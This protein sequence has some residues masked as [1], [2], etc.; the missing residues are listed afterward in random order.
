LAALA[1]ETY[2]PALLWTNRNKQAN[3]GKRKKVTFKISRNS[4]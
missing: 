1:Y 2:Q 4:Q 3:F